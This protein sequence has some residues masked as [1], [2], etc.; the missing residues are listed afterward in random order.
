[1]T[2]EA[3]SLTNLLDDIRDKYDKIPSHKRQQL[4][5]AYDPCIDVLTELDKLLEH[6]NTLDTKSKRAWD[7]L[8]WDPEKSRSL[9]E[10]LASSVA[11]LNAFYTSLIHDNQ[12]L[13]LEAL[14]R[15][16]GDY[17]GGYREE[18]VASIERIAATD[19]QEAEDANDAAWTQII[20]DLEDV[21]ISHQ[22]VLTY[23]DFVVDWFIKAVNE[24]RLLEERR[25]PESPNSTRRPSCVAFDM[26]HLS[27]S[28]GPVSSSLVSETYTEEWFPNRPTTIAVPLQRSDSSNAPEPLH[29]SGYPVETLELLHE[30]AAASDTT[31]LVHPSSP[32]AQAPEPVYGTDRDDAPELVRPSIPASEALQPLQSLASSDLNWRAQQILA[33]WDRREWTAAAHLL[34]EQLAAVEQGVVTSLGSQPDRR[35]LRHCVG[36]CATFN[37]NLT[38]AKHFFESAFNGIYLTRDLDDGDIAAARWLGDVCLQLREFHNAVL[39]WCVAL[40]GSIKRY[41]L[42]H[43]RTRHIAH[44]LQKM[45]EWLSVFKNIDDRFRANVDPTDIFSNTHALEKSDLVSSIRLRVPELHKRPNAA[46]NKLRRPGP[47]LRPRPRLELTPGEGFLVGPL[48]SLGAWPLQWDS[49]FSPM[50]SYQ[51]EWYMKIATPSLALVDR[52][53]RTASL[54]DSKKLDYVTKESSAWLIES[55]KAV[56]R[57]L[58]IE[59]AEHPDESIVVCCYNRERDGFACTEGIFISF[60][61]LQFRNVHGLQVSSVRWSTRTPPTNKPSFTDKQANSLMDFETPDTIDFR[62]TV[63]NMLELAEGGAP[64]MIPI[65]DGASVRSGTRSWKSW[66]SSKKAAAST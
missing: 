16:E 47:A 10:R 13:I 20:R 49:T 28:L 39:A 41:G 54:G 7:R 15:L 38:K 26:R 56:L 46:R 59:H 63:K 19:S 52:S 30:P 65:G 31:E 4:I 33:A 36:V 27:T 22:I 12:V 51:M 37:G 43:E 34:E 21:G 62:N 60:W 53:L 35:I 17:K 25:E 14:E 66:T 58:N 61:K 42:S 1:M 23:R 24:G 50:A 8:K 6:Y 45:D 44:E 55:V 29:I 57:E 48:V 3:R 40:D 32:A 64:T 9:R 5:D 2:T 11:M 18:S